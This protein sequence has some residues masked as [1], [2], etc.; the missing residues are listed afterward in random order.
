MGAILERAPL[1]GNDPILTDWV[2]LSA[3]QSVGLSVSQSAELSV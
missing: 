2:G 3:L 1:L